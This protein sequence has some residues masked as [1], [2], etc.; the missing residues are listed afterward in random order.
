MDSDQ[1]T[2]PQVPVAPIPVTQKSTSQTHSRKVLLI[3]LGVLE[4]PLSAIFLYVSIPL[5]ELYNNLG[6]NSIAPY[7]G[8]GIFAIALLVALTQIV[9]G[10]FSLDLKFGKQKTKDLIIL[11]LILAVLTLPAF[12][13]V[14]MPIYGIVSPEIGSISY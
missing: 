5:I 13:N 7:I 14:I 6:T 12:I 10:L 8:L 4:I 2:P 3:I 11:G 9:L 1:S